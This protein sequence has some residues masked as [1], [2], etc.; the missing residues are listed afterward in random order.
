MEKQEILKHRKNLFHLATKK[1]LVKKGN[2]RI[3]NQ[4][5][6]SLCGRVLTKYIVT[7][8]KWYCIVPHYRLHIQNL[9]EFNLC[10]DIKSCYTHIQK[11]EQ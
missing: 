8:R 4:R 11:K 3:H 10:Q 6:C 1:I 5:L 7:E 2:Q 9:I